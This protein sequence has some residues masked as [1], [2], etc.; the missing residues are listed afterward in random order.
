MRTPYSKRPLR[1]ES[2]HDSSTMSCAS[3]RRR[4][5]EPGK[6]EATETLIGTYLALRSAAAT[7]AAAAPP[8]V[9]RIDAAAN[10][11]EPAKVVADISR[12]AAQPM[13]ASPDSR[14]NEAPKSSGASASGRAARTP[15]RM[16]VEG[17]PRR[18]RER[19]FRPGNRLAVSGPA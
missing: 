12:A 18:Y 14:P 15:S 8:P 16:R 19:P 5:R 7:I 2:A 17:M 13:P 10:C 4:R 11:A 9:S 1:P 6:I 3:T